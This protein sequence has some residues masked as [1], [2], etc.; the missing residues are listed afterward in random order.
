MKFIEE[1]DAQERLDEILDEAQQRPIVI[2][3]KAKTS[4]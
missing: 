4:L 2:R 3:S 1:A